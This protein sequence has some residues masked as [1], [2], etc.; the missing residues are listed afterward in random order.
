MKLNEI[1]FYMILFLFQIF[2][3]IIITCSE[4]L[5]EKKY[6]FNYLKMAL[7]MF[8]IGC[9]MEII[10]WNYLQNFECIFFTAIPL[11]LI[12]IIKL[13]TF[14]FKFIFKNEPFQIYRNELSDGIWVKNNGNFDRYKFYYSFY[15]ISILL[16]PMFTLTL[17][18]I[19]LFK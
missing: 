3:V 9:F 11:A 10:N 18:Y 15:S 16:I 8:S 13:I 7:L 19:F 6:F 2:S 12:A 4:D 14:I 5:K 1:Y 17:F